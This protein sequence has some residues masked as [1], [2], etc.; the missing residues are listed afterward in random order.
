M[1]RQEVRR[2]VGRPAKVIRLHG[3]LCWQYSIDEHVPAFGKYDGYT[4]DAVGVCFYGGKY[5]LFHSKIDGKWDHK[6]SS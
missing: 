3:L 6:P 1:T 4:F 5:T 2:R